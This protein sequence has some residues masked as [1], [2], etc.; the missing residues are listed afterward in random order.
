MAIYCKCYSIE[1]KKIIR[2]IL[3]KYK[4]HIVIHTY[5]NIR[6]FDLFTKLYC[7]F[8]I[9]LLH[10]TESPTKLNRLSKKIC[11]IIFGLITHNFI[12]STS[13]LSHWPGNE[14]KHTD[15]YFL[16]L[17]IPFSLRYIP[18]EEACLLF[19]GGIGLL[20]SL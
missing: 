17:L 12:S 4:F 14:S 11:N 10:N 15:N 16:A 18:I 9:T 19:N 13:I 20:R 3:Y 5:N 8:F 1:N 6:T 7:L 2:I